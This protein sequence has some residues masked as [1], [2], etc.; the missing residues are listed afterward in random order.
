MADIESFKIE[1]YGNVEV[2]AHSRNGNIT[3]MYWNVP[4][5]VMLKLITAKKNP[6]VKDF[7]DWVTAAKEKKHTGGCEI[8]C[9]SFWTSDD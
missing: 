6:T 7:D 5:S 4:K 3:H 2:T 1:S 9:S 8:A